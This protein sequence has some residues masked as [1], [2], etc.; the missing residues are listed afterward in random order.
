MQDRT[1]ADKWVVAAR[2]LMAIASAHGDVEV[3]IPTATGADTP[4]ADAEA[5]SEGEGEGLVSSAA[6]VRP[7][8]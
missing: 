8:S 7:G 1:A 5:E 3:S 4:A 2:R 6:D